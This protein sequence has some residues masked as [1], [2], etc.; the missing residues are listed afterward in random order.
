VVQGSTNECH[1]QEEY[2]VGVLRARATMTSR[3]S[4]ALIGALGGL[5]TVRA[6]NV[7]VGP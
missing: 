4:H 3:S 5:A 1:R 6:G 7:G 2:I